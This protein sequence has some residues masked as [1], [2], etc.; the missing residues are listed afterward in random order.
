MENQAIALCETRTLGNNLVC[1]KHSGVLS[2]APSR[3]IENTV[4]EFARGIGVGPFRVK[5]GIEVIHG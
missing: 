2:W 1:V 5:N 4:A 3:V